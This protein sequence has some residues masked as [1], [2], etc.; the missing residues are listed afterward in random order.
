[1]GCARHR[2]DLEL[3]LDAR[4]EAI[5]DAHQTIEREAGKVGIADSGKVRCR[6]AGARVRGA[7][8]QA[9]LGGIARH[10]ANDSAVSAQ[11]VADAIKYGINANK[12][13]PL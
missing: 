5:D 10:L 2:L 1:M 13:K 12:I 9:V 7:H 4:P 6:D 8:C 3:D 11:K